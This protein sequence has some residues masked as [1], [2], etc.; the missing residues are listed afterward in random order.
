MAAFRHE[1]GTAGARVTGHPA[2]MARRY[3][4]A[5]VIAE[6][7]KR[8]D[9]RDRSE[10]E[11]S[12]TTLDSEGRDAESRPSLFLPG[13]SYLTSPKNATRTFHGRPT[14]RAHSLGGGRVG[15]P[16]LTS[17][18]RARQS[19]RRC[20]TRARRLRPVKCEQVQ[21]I[22]RLDVRARSS[23]ER[24]RHVARQWAVG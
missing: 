10:N 5:S 14:C 24:A 15:A 6:E 12:A 19:K 11:S 22:A 13:H 1:A 17:P 4:S 20:P 2:T 9:N 16:A 8:W 18:R 21:G 7:S 3:G 23:S